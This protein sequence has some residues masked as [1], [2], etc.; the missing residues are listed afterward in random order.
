ML[1]TK[2]KCAL[3]G[4]ENVDNKKLK[5]KTIKN[6]R[7]A[8]AAIIGVIEFIGDTHFL[9]SWKVVLQRHQTDFE[10]VTD[11]TLLLQISECGQCG[12]VAYQCRR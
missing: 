12:Q 11:R 9:Q 10:A 5:V 6:R 1:T 8:M 2:G 4:G 7:I 3:I